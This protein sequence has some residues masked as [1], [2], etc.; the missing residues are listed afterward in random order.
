MC[1]AGF[2]ATH[3]CH[4]FLL[5]FPIHECTQYMNIRKEEDIRELETPAVINAIKHWW[6]IMPHVSL[7]ILELIVVDDSKQKSELQTCTT[8]LII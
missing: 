3:D 5:H 1:V 8:R 6:Q 2:A 4:T 7:Y